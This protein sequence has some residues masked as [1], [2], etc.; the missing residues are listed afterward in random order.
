MANAAPSLRTAEAEKLVARLRSRAKYLLGRHK[1]REAVTLLSEAIRLSPE[2]Y[3][4]CH[5]RGLAHA[6]LHEYDAALAD[7]E[8]VVRL[9]PGSPD[10]HYQ[11]G[12][13][14]Y[15]T[16][17]F[18]AAAHAFRDALSICPSDRIMR[19][20]FWDAMALLSQNRSGAGGL[21]RGRRAAG[22]AAG[23]EWEE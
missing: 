22:E 19:Q 13:A 3:K 1:F 5:L 20:A 21:A 17:E 14:L 2:S 23:P 4:L 9:K 11:K 16:G 6:C 8:T 7:A 12:F 10:G 15:H 18:A